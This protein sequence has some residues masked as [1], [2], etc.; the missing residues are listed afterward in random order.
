[1]GWEIHD[2]SSKGVGIVSQESY[3]VGGLSVGNF[4]QCTIEASNQ[5]VSGLVRWMNV[6][7][8]G[9]IS[10][11][12]EFLARENIPVYLQ[13]KNQRKEGFK[14]IAILGKYTF[15]PWP[16]NIIIAQGG[17]YREGESLTLISGQ[18]HIEIKLAACLIPSK[19]CKIFS[20]KAEEVALK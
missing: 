6:K 9:L 19:N 10:I 8:G 3:P 12:S 5:W 1:M 18:N 14:N 7:E 2:E 16:N 15:K 17:S 4:V 20:F 11:A 13:S